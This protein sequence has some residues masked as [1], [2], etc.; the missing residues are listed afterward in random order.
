VCVCVCVCVCVGACVCV[1][2]CVCLYVCVY[3]ADHSQKPVHVCILCVM[4]SCVHTQEAM[5]ADQLRSG[6]IAKSVLQLQQHAKSEA[7]LSMHTHTHTHT[8]TYAHTHAHTHI[9]KLI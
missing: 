1:C 4:C 3:V 6:K 7:G 9:H 5:T 2:A 8:R